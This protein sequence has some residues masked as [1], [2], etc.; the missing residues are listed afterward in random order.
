MDWNELQIQDSAYALEHK[1][2]SIFLDNSSFV[3]EDGESSWMVRVRI[4]IGWFSIKQQL[5]L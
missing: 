3:S 5:G 4:F 2:M 1:L